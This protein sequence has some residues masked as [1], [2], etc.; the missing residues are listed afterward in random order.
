LQMLGLSFLLVLA[1]AVM[2]VDAMFGVLFLG[3]I[4]AGLSALVLQN[5]RGHWESAGGE[6]AVLGR[7]RGVL[8][9]AFGIAVAA[10]CVGILLFTLLIY[11]AF[12]R[13]GFRMWR[14]DINLQS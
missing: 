3:Y 1:A 14:A 12:P 13:V 11:F 10:L 7:R 2:T 5:L 8:G 4:F 9:R 6:T